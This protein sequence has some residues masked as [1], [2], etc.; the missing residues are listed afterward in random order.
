MTLPASGAL[1]LSDI[2]TEFGGSNPISISEYYGAAAGVPSSGA[3]SFSDF[4]G[5]SSFTLEFSAASYTNHGIHATGGTASA[6]ILI[7][8][9]GAVTGSKTSS[10][11]GLGSTAS[12]TWATPVAA[13][14]GDDYEIRATLN[15]GSTP[16][17][18]LGT[19]LA[20][21]S[22]RQWSISSTGAAGLVTCNLTLEIRDASTLVVEDSCIAILTADSQS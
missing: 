17:G 18:T 10:P 4:Y 22:N 7:S 21:T 8:N 12:G 2:Q 9:T 5:T 14:N 13:G 15:S 11:S 19:W 16:T 6:A 3:I 20:L 1:A